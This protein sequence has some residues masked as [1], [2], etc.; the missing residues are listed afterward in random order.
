LMDL[1]EMPFSSSKT[2]VPSHQTTQCL[3]QKDSNVYRFQVA[4]I[5]QTV[6]NLAGKVYYKF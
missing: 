2:L 1:D 6:Y 5:S 3:I 4:Q